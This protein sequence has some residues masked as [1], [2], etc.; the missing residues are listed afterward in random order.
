M[1]KIPVINPVNPV[2]VVNPVNPVQSVHFVN[3]VNPVHKDEALVNA[4][5]PTLNIQLSTLIQEAEK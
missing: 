1:D 4:K 2:N 3:P 5:H